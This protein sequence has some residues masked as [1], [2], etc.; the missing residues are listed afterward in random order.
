MRLLPAEADHGRGRA[1]PPGRGVAEE[2]R[3]ATEDDPDGIRNIC[4]CG[5]YPRIR[6]AVRPA[7]SAAGRM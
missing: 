4:R 1:G 5:S 6:E 3:E 7:R 2:G